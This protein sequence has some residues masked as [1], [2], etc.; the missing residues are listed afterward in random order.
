MIILLSGNGF[1][2]VRKCVSER[3]L[4]SIADG[5]HGGIFSINYKNGPGDTENSIMYAGLL[6]HKIKKWCA[7]I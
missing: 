3:S 1:N 6:A 4:K 7:L 5:V 2:L